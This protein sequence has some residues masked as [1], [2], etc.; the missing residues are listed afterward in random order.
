M[1][2]P[3][4]IP[5]EPVVPRPIVPEPVV[6]EPVVPEPMVSEPLAPE[7]VV[8]DPV[9]PEPRVP[10]LP[11]MVPSERPEPLRVPVVVPRREDPLVVVSRVV[12]PAPDIV[13]PVVLEPVAV[14]DG[15]EPVVEPVVVEPVLEPVVE[16]PVEPAPE[17]LPPVVWASAGP[18]TSA[19]AAIDV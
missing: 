11:R 13:E 3:V 17:P 10:E 15:L 16:E 4:P 7:P 6:P 5:P 9:V 12:E 2:E 14:P 19:R 1:L 18:A 8:P